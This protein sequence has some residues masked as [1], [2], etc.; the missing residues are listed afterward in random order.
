MRFQS[1]R[2]SSVLRNVSDA[3]LS[4]INICI[5]AYCFS[6]IVRTLTEPWG[7]RKDLMMPMFF[8]ASSWLRV[9]RQYTDN[10]TIKNPFLIRFV[11]NKDASRRSLFV[12]VGKSNIT[13]IR[14][15]LL[16]TIIPL[17]KHIIHLNFWNFQ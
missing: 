13:I 15:T 17:E 7:G 3:V 12:K 6:V 2:I 10:C 5:E 9:T 16:F 4:P 14:I 1:S 11:R 8:L